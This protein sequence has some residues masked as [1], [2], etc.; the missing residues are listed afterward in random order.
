MSKVWIADLQILGPAFFFGIGFIGQ[1]AVS[2]EGLGP[3]T[4][5]ALRFALL[6]FL[7]V[8]AVPFL[9]PKF[10]SGGEGGES[11]DKE[12]GDDDHSP[13]PLTD[14]GSSSGASMWP[15]FLTQLSPM[16][17]PASQ[18]SVLHWGI[19]LGCINFLGSGLQQ[20]GITFTAANKVAF[21]ACF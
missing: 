7:L 13:S 18:K 20:V 17:S 1:R 2:V 19:Y 3:M 4:C 11:T 15:K 9:P 6:A 21:I 5:N 16:S 10:F 8:A 14:S 12:K